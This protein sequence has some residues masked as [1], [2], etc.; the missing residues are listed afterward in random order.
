MV[1]PFLP[2]ASWARS[3]DRSAAAGRLVCIL[4]FVTSFTEGC[5]VD[6]VTIVSN[7]TSLF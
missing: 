2:S 4:R 3:V 6:L 5:Q 1:E 7:V